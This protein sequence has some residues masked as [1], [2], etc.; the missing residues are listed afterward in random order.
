VLGP[1]IDGEIAESS[2]GHSG[3]KSTAG[4]TP[5]NP[6]GSETRAHLEPLKTGVPKA[7]SQAVAARRALTNVPEEYVADIDRKETKWSALIKS[8][9]RERSDVC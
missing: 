6:A 9:E 3:P 4:A 7:F 5:A 1:E 2:F 8:P